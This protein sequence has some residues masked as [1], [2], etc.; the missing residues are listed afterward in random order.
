MN[1]AEE[2]YNK[3]KITEDMLDYN[4]ANI[5]CGDYKKTID[6]YIKFNKENLAYNEKYK[7]TIL[8]IYFRNKIIE[9]KL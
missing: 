5:L 6:P 2:L 4:V 1:K 9:R 3:I 8:G 7:N